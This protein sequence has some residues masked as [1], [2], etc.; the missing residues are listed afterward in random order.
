M[1]KIEYFY[2]GDYPLYFVG[3][4]IF[5]GCQ[6]GTIDQ[7]DEVAK[8]YSFDVQR[9]KHI[10]YK[11]HNPDEDV[12]SFVFH[13]DWWVRIEVARQGYGLEILVKDEDWWVRRAVAEQGYGLNILINDKDFRVRVA[14]ASQGYG[15]EILVKDE[16]WWVRRAVAQ[17]GYGLDILINDKDS[18]VRFAA[19][20]QLQIINK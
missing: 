8:K 1:K 16:D 6:R 9:V 19:K 2:D 11:E 14:V 3:K 17:Q 5:C 7:V 15:L 18:Y 4:Y 13:E 10:Y 12:S 20:K